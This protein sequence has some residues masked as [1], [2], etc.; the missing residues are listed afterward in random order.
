MVFYHESDL[1]QTLSLTQ[2]QR[3][4]F[5][6]CLLTIPIVAYFPAFVLYCVVCLEDYVKNVAPSFD[7]RRIW[8]FATTIG[9]KMLLSRD[10][11]GK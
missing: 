7:F 3:G 8:E 10:K 5:P 4:H 9:T 2:Q 1:G 11:L 6:M